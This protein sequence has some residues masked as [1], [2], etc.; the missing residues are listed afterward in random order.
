MSASSRVSLRRALVAV[1]AA[2][3]IVTAAPIG[4]GAGA[5]PAEITIPLKTGVLTVNGFAMNWPP[6]AT[7]G[8]KLVGVWDAETGALEASLD[9]APV[10]LTYPQL[11]GGEGSVTMVA[12]DFTGTVL[13]GQ[14]GAVTGS[15]VVEVRSTGLR[16]VEVAPALPAENVCES[17]GAIP[18]ESTLTPVEGGYQLTLTATG[19]DFPLD[20]GY[21]P[22]SDP[23]TT[24][25]VA[26]TEAATG[27]PTTETALTITGF[28]AVA[29]PAPPAPTPTPTPAAPKFTG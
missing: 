6:P 8:A 15:V 2:S 18:F 9:S 12:G 25:D 19:F 11:T 23:G 10:T 4:A 3:L 20:S 14:T 24:C 7:T 22:L 5:A 16:P 27:T 13:P 29:P 1:M 26:F 28:V 17:S 21:T